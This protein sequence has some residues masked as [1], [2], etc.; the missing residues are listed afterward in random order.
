[1]IQLSKEESLVERVTTSEF[2]IEVAD[3]LK[4]LA[5]DATLRDRRWTWLCAAALSL[6]RQLRRRASQPTLHLMSYGW[7]LS[8]DDLQYRLRNIIHP[9]GFV[10]RGSRLTPKEAQLLFELNADE[11][12]YLSMTDSFTHEDDSSSIGVTAPVTLREH[13]SGVVA[14]ADHF[15][16]AAR[17]SPIIAADIQ[18]AARLHD[19]GKSDPRF[20]AWLLGGA[21]RVARIA[22][23]TL[24]KSGI[25]MDQASSRLARVRSGY[26]NGARHELL[27]IRLT[28]SA[29]EWLSQANDPDLVL[30]LIGAHHGCCRPFAPVVNDTTSGSI[31]RPFD[32]RQLANAVGMSDP[33]EPEIAAERVLPTRLDD[34]SSGVGRRFWLLVRRYGWWGLAWLET[35]LILADRCESQREQEIDEEPHDA[36]TLK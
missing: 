25:S 34:V 17:L 11:E 21:P 36:E 24:A 12:D 23:E 26:P 18:L 14:F 3:A 13:T 10:I 7:S 15:T 33:I 29:T 31:K 6:S 22:T 4:E 30:H 27:S 8:G 9:G 20:Q 28:E 35:H 16:T 2:A 1:M 19:I 5:Q 32:L